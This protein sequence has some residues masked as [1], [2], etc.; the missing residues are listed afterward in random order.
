MEKLYEYLE[1]AKYQY[2][3]AMKGFV[4]KNYDSIW[5]FFTLRMAIE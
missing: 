4:P 3:I 5:D 2:E 1:K